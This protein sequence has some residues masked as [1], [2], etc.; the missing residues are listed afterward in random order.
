[1]TI[2]AA[3]TARDHPPRRRPRTQERAGRVDRHH[4]LP[5]GQRQIDGGAA[6]CD[7]GV[8]DENVDA[9]PSRERR[10]AH[11]LDGGFAD[12]VGR[13]REGGAAARDD[14]AGRLASRRL[15]EVGDDDMGAHVGEGERVAVRCRARRPV[16][17][18]TA[19]FKLW[20]ALIRV[21]IRWR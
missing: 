16:T 8:V 17:I 4:L 15:V 12:D 13:L 7:A 10:L 9:A 1:M 3:A 11:R 18:A 21:C 20:P 19:P 5:F 14:L 6:D 2:G